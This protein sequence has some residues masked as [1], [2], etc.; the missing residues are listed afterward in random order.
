LIWP[1]LGWAVA[2]LAGLFLF[3]TLSFMTYCWRHSAAVALVV[4]PTLL[5]SAYASGLGAARGFLQPSAVV[6]L[7]NREIS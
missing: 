5:L 3:T 6:K 7:H 1:P 2:L 4:P